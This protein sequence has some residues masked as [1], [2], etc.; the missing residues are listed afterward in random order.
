TPFLDR[1][2][3]PQAWDRAMTWVDCQLPV[4]NEIYIYYGGYKGGHKVERFTERQV[5]LAR[6]GLDR[7]AAR[8]AGV[9]T[10]AILTHPLRFA[11]NTLTVNAQVNGSLTVGAYDSEGHP[12]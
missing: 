11:G 2:A 8:T 1:S 12:L 5:G 4:G 10:G 6:M 9:D 7:Y 3:V